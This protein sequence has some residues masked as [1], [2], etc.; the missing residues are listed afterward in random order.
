MSIA[1]TIH[2]LV[3]YYLSFAHPAAALSFTPPTPTQNNIK[4][5]LK[6]GATSI[7][8]RPE[9]AKE[10]YAHRSA[11][12]STHGIDIRV[13]SEEKGLGAFATAPIS[14]GTL[15]GN[16]NGE[17]FMLSQVHARFWN[18]EE[19]N[20][21]DLFWED[22]RVRRGQGI[23]GHFLF[24]IPGRMFVDAEDADVS[25]WVRFMNHAEEESEECNVKAFLKA[26]IVDEVVSFPLMYAIRDIGVV[27]QRVFSFVVAL[28]VRVCV[29]C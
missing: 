20:E 22:S 13:A 6:G 9:L 29:C 18:K 24:E 12:E 17:V 14:S 28:Y 7:G 16:Y 10:S 3:L 11:I 27:R 15:L 2:V 8:I 21:Q 23:T 5:N 4:E 26:M 19:K 1:T 25:C